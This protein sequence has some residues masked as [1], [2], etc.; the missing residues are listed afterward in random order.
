MCQTAAFSD[1]SNSRERDFPQKQQKRTAQRAAVGSHVAAMS[2][3]DIA[4]ERRAL[5]GP[6]AP[7]LQPN[8]RIT[9]L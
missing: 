9:R 7:R 5:M 2:A 3:T 6:P 4:E 1:S 8:V